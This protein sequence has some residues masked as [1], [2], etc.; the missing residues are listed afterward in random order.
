MLR[1][2]IRDIG[3]YGFS[4]MLVRLIS[5]LLIPLYVRVLSTDD[6]GIIDLISL[7]G[8]LSGVVLSL[9]LYQSVSRYFAG[10]GAVSRREYASTGLMFYLYSY[11]LFTTLMLVFAEQ[12]SELIFSI[13]GREEIFR[14]A[15]LSMPVTALFSYF[16]N[17]LRY[18][19]QSVKYSLI[20]IFYS[21]ATILLSVLFVVVLN[22]G[23]SGV[24]LGLI[25]GG[26][27]SIM[28]SIWFNKQHLSF[29]WSQQVMKQML[30]FSLPLTAS[31]LA[32]YSLTYFDRILIRHFLSLS[33]LGVYAVAFRIAA[34]PVV[35]MSIVNSSFLPLIYKHYRES[36]ISRDLTRIYGYGFVGGIALI[37]LLS[38]FS[39]SI[40]SIITTPE[41]HEAARVLPL[42]LFSGFLIQF[43]GMFVGLSLAEKTSIT[44]LIYA[45]GLVLNLVLNIYLIPTLGI[46]G[47]GWSA[48]G[49]SVLILVLQIW[50]SE[51]YYPV[52]RRK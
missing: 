36:S 27:P 17:M 6:Y 11:T 29:T 26:I 33:D 18:S 45:G 13:K 52:T 43:A 12:L 47:A 19:L 14:I 21:V 50:F 34:I 39:G 25:A 22:Q 10:G 28:L 32:I 41:Y 44:A 16:Q 37:T 48:L 23:L 30:R 5:F 46:T 49:S 51:K 35:L 1:Q 40:I 31:A 3:V 42:L 24:Y 7:F 2:F 15:V 20:N 8:T 38:L 9:E 4:G